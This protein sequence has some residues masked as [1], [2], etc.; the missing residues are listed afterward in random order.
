MPNQFKGQVFDSNGNKLSGVKVSITGPSTIPP[1]TSTTTDV[2]GNWLITLK[3]DIDPKDIS[4]TFSK[5]GLETTSIKNPQQTSVLPGYIDPVKGGTLDLAGDYPSGKYKIIS[6]PQETQDIINKEIE[7]AYNFAKNNPGNF[8]LEIESSESQVPNA[9]NEGTNKDFSKPGSLAQARAEALLE[10]VNDKINILY[11]KEVNPT[12]QKPIVV[13]GN[14][15]RVGDEPWD[16]I[17]AKANKYTKDQYTRVKANL[18]TKRKCDWIEVGSDV[19]Q[20]GEPTLIKGI[21]ANNIELDAA[22]APDIFIISGKKSNGT[23]IEKQTP[24]YYQSPNSPSSPISWGIIIYMSDIARGS[25]TQYRLPLQTK[26]ISINEAVNYISEGY[27]SDG[28]KTYS[29][30]IKELFKKKSINISTL[31]SNIILAGLQ[32]YFPTG[33]VTYYVVDRSY[34]TFPLIENNITGDFEVKAVNGLFIGG[35]AFSYK[36]CV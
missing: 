17:D 8:I 36:M 20:A 3:V 14:I 31:D 33:I 23:F 25:L 29:N 27:T 34:Y 15:N 22:I 12:F 10:F 11:T 32:K 5:P 6:L 24:I 9:D 30:N 28:T 18:V 1:N 7:D 13:P 2:N 4:V 16:K 19:I 26:T 35:S 21:G